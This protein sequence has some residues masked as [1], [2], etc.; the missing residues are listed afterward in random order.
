[1][2]RA[3][4]PQI[5]T[6]VLIAMKLPH[7]HHHHRHHH[8]NL[9]LNQHSHASRFL[10]RRESAR[11]SAKAS[12]MRCQ[13][14]ICFASMSLVSIESLVQS[15]CAKWCFEDSFFFF[16]FFFSYVTSFSKYIQLM[17]GG[18]PAYNLDDPKKL[19][20]FTRC[21]KLRLLPAIPDAMRTKKALKVSSCATL[22]F[23]PLF[24]IDFYNRMNKSVKWMIGVRAWSSVVWRCSRSVQ[25]SLRRKRPSVPSWP[26]IR[27]RSD[28]VLKMHL[29]AA[30]QRQSLTPTAR[31]NFEC[32]SMGRQGKEK[33][34]A[35]PQ[36]SFWANDVNKFGRKMLERMGWSDGKGLGA[37]G[38]GT[39][40][41]IEVVRKTDNAGKKQKKTE[42]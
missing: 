28:V 35:D 11:A 5:A 33:M 7:N 27:L 37:N 42:N 30:H 26:T 1:M 39:T 4:D 40:T 6:L 21:A 38:E 14:V 17:G 10:T 22:T 20:A 23:A 16:F 32:R 18:R 3:E 19:E 25:C 36:N 8:L 9:N 41:H 12:D 34:A 13:S 31:T 29:R 15:M 24:L 2:T